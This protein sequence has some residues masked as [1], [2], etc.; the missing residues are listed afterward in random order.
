[1]AAHGIGNALM[2]ELVYG[3]DGQLLSASF[4][5]YLLP[6]ALEMPPMVL[7]PFET[8]SPNNPLGVKG[9]GESGTIGALSSVANAVS[10]AI[11]PLGARIPDVPLTPEKVWKAIKQASTKA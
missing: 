9:V 7:E 6:T 11:A 4:M 3:D 1:G 8:L 10:D 5:D 2:E